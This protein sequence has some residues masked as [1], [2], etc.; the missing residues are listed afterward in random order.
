MNMPNG[1]RIGRPRPRR[2][3]RTKIWER[4]YAALPLKK[5]PDQGGETELSHDEIGAP[6]RADWTNSFLSAN[7]DELERLAIATRIGVR[8]GRTHVVLTSSDRVGAI[9]IRS[10]ITRKIIGG[11]LVEP[12]FGWQSIGQVLGDVGFRVEPK[13]GGLA[14]VPGSAREVPPWVLAGPV[15]ARVAALVARMNRTFVQTTVEREMPRGTVNWNLYA[16]RALPSGKWTSFQCSYSELCNDPELVAALRWTLRRVR[17][18]LEP[19][20]ELL[21]ARRLLERIDDLLREL[22]LGPVRRP[23]L[24]ELEASTFAPEWLR[25]AVEAVGWVRDERG[26]GGARSL[27]GL[28]WSLPVNSLWEAWVEAFLH[29]LAM[30]LGGRLF[31][32]REGSTRRPLVWR[33]HTR[34]LGHLAPDF[35]LEL[36]GRSVWIDAKYKDHLRRLT[37]QDWSVLPQDLRE[38]HRADLHQALAYAMLSESR[39][40]DTF[41]V[42]PSLVGSGGDLRT[43]E[44]LSA[45]AE[46]VAG[47]RHVRLGLGSIPFGFQGPAHRESVVSGW[48]RSLRNVV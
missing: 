40:V 19:A 34:S 43:T 18:D 27:D 7:R 36:P 9:P 42:Y 1:R 31:T 39:C 45:L 12:R 16:G 13:I 44:P 22:G 8:D 11:I 37:V 30:R 47:E 6:D 46:L 14:L 21:V 41:L 48:E 32:A 24:G 23:G 2:T 4:G 26:L 33:T 28:P 10:P 15:V 35:L 5:L 25:L 20:I 38:S 29:S 17:Q 3:S